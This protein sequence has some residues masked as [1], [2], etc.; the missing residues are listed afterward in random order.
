MLSSLF[1]QGFLCINIL[2]GFC[3]R[4]R[5]YVVWFF[6]FSSRIFLK[7]KYTTYFLV[8]TCSGHFRI[9]TYELNGCCRI[10][11][12]SSH[13]C[14]GSWTSHLSG[15]LLKVPL[16]VWL[17]G[18]LSCEGSAVLPL[19]LASY[20]MGPPGALCPPCMHLSLLNIVWVLRPCL[21]LW[22]ELKM[23]H[24]VLLYCRNECTALL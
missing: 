15:L 20:L 18:R 24:Y 13:T 6:P 5:N 16:H 3:G 17:C 21:S 23:L 11:K 19:V 9:G 7:K 2:L 8:G 4:K 12:Y 14:S 1:F 10:C 22:E